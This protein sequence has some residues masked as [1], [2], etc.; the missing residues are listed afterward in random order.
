[1]GW[2][3]CTMLR[4]DKAEEIARS[5]VIAEE[6]ARLALWRMD[7]A[8]TPIISQ[9]SVYPYF[10]FIPFYPA[11]R[12]YSNMFNEAPSDFLIPS[13][14]KDK[15]SPYIHLHFQ[16]DPDGALTSPEVPVLE[17]S[18]SGGNHPQN[19]EETPI[20][21]MERLKIIV[22]EDVL[23]SSL[24]ERDARLNVRPDDAQNPPGEG[25]QPPRLV[26]Q[27]QVQ[28]PRAFDQ[29]E[30][31]KRAEFS[32]QAI[33]FN[34]G[35]NAMNFAPI[36]ANVSGGVMQ[37]LW[38]GDN[39]FLARRVNVNG[40]DY[41]QGCWIDWETLRSWLL[42]SISDLLP[43][44]DL[45]SAL[46]EPGNGK[47]RMLAT[48]PVNLIPGEVAIQGKSGLSP[49]VFILIIAWI[50]VLTAVGAAGGLL[51]GAISL[52]ERRAAFVSAVTHELRT[53]ITTLRMY[54]EML[55]EG[56]IEDP[57]KRRNYL[58]TITTEADRLGHLVENVLTFARL[59]RRRLNYN[60]EIL[61]VNE[62]LNRAR[63]RLSR[64]AMQSGMEIVI[65]EQ[66]PE[67]PAFV[68]T[69]FLVIEQILFNLIDNS[70][71]YAASAQ[72]RRIH[73]ETGVA[74]GKAF[75]KVRDHGPGISQ[76][77][78]G[79]LFRA[80]GKSAGEAAN[81][82]PGVGLGLA[83]CRRLA[84]MMSGDLSLD[85]TVTDGACFALILP[86]AP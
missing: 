54:T 8:L 58:E 53:P 86:G 72:D 75:I 12:A 71:K 77:D 76:K 6:N 59:E 44:A 9:E 46:P 68:K 47:E 29:R 36:T 22:D 69:D 74:G 35:N 52:S 70:C 84:R 51:F 55:S 31:E 1:M 30:W 34:I 4:L 19:S 10:Y 13:P 79:R 67:R 25:E 73:I 23:A 56:M 60:H 24:S 11:S 18:A 41:I 39:L 16:F 15:R 83:L 81:S 2:L 50:S 21:K 62:I 38:L 57:E 37:P 28:R 80:F 3:S 82:A 43:D 63:E 32:Q 26:S 14:L 78:A 65:E 66:N 42:K 20:G 40:R 5:R 85:R 33:D 7:S 27:A 49:I 64:R 61:S 17:S 45:K 48:L